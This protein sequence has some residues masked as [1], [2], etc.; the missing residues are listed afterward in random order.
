MKKPL[1]FI[2]VLVTMLAGCSPSGFTFKGSLEDD[3]LQGSVLLYVQNMQS[4]KMDTLAFA[5]VVNGKFTLAGSVDSLAIAMLR[6][7]IEGLGESVVM[8]TVAKTY[9]YTTH[10]WQERFPVYVE[11]ARYTLKYSENGVQVQGTELM[12]LVNQYMAIQ[13]GQQV[14]NRD[15]FPRTV[16][17]F[18]GGDEEVDDEAE[19]VKAERMHGIEEAIW[20]QTAAL[21]AKHRNSPVTAYYLSQYSNAF[22]VA[23][24]KKNF[25][26]LGEVARNTPEGQR[27]DR[28]IKENLVEIE[29]KEPLFTATT[30]RS[31]G[32]AGD[33][34]G[35]TL[36]GIKYLAAL[37]DD[38]IAGLCESGSIVVFNGKG[39]KTKEIKTGVEK[40]VVL[41]ADKAGNY[42]VLARIGGE[43]RNATGVR[44]VVLD[45]NGKKVREYTIDELS[46]PSGV[47][48]SEGSL[49]V[50]D[51]RKRAVCIYDAVTGA[52]KNEVAN[53]RSCCGI[54]DFA[55]SPEN[56]MLIANLGA[57]RVDYYNP[58]LEMVGAFGERG[59]LGEQFHGC[60]NPVNVACLSDGSVLSVEKDP[61][62]IKIFHNAKEATVVD[63]VKELVKGC[64]YIPLAVDSK[65]NIYL[66]SP[67]DGVVKCSVL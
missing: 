26:R 23:E 67:K 6:F 54:L 22:P 12:D 65:D 64:S 41:A 21:L 34:A 25:A 48:V 7:D 19:R 42:Y 47:K 11:N 31:Y 30:Q 66:A 37:S 52:K 44:C 36:T 27:L 18:L 57:F 13:Q 5:P 49:Y 60:C 28:Y 8:D 45:K 56:R 62:R 4:R 3:S 32:I 55:I 43:D 16:T 58:E 17:Y 61:T 50:A 29:N 9:T 63:G 51:T 35:N 2:A 40:P 1:L 24:L 15:L 46:S 20:N 33:F 59:R 38:Q 14:A 10:Y 53:L 39:A